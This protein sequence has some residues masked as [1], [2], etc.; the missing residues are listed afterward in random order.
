MEW[1]KAEDIAPYQDGFYL[2]CLTYIDSL[3]RQKHKIKVCRYDSI[4]DAWYMGI[5]LVQVVYWQKLPEAP[6]DLY[7]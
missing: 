6:K 3:G 5:A 2:A 4:D 1:N 7:N